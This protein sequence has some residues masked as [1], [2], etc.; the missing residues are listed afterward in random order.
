M[1]KVKLIFN[2]IPAKVGELFINGK[3]F[4]DV[5]RGDEEDF[6]QGFNYK[7][8][9]YDINIYEDDETGEIKATIYEVVNGET[10]TNGDEIPVEVIINS[11]VIDLD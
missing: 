1:K 9:D 10:L 8:K 2:T 3:Y 7:G 11:Q 6:W 4:D 5:E